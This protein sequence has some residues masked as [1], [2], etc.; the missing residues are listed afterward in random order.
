MLPAG[1]AG[2]GVLIIVHGCSRMTIEGGGEAYILLGSLH[3]V[4][5]H[6]AWFP[7]VGSVLNTKSPSGTIEAHPKNLKLLA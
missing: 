6:G 7:E 3:D 1:A 4:Y 2:G 5:V